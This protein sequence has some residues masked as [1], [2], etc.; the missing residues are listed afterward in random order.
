MEVV[1]WDGSQDLPYKAEAE[2]YI[3]VSNCDISRH[4]LHKHHIHITDRK[5]GRPDYYILYVT[6]GKLIFE[7]D[8]KKH[9]AFP[10]DIAVYYPDVPQKITRLPENKGENYW[11]HFNGYAI[12]EILLQSGLEKSGIYTVGQSDV[13]IDAFNQLMLALKLS[14]S[15]LHINSLF[16]QIMT[17]ISDGF[18]ATRPGIAASRV[19]KGIMQMDW[20]YNNAERSIAWYAGLCNMSPARY[21]VVF[22]KATGKT[23]SQFLEE[24]RI[25]KA[26]DML[27]KTTLSIS[28][29]AE[30]VGYRDAL[31]FSRVF[32]K[33]TGISPTDFRNSKTQS[34]K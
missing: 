15:K 21:A 27:T 12:P 13:L 8:G 5:A 33:H 30:N 7:F 31:Y 2:E 11:M 32:R 22:K 28:Q 1:I 6:S 34:K 20:E 19:L 25:S 18:E 16:M 29:V 14:Q 17:L 9:E 3:T 10:G 23:P 4:Q 24:R 26:K